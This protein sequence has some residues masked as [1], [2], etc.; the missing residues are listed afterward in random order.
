MTAT[1]PI[2]HS[3]TAHFIERWN[4]VKTNKYASNPRYSVLDPGFGAPSVQNVVGQLS[5]RLSDRLHLSH[6]GYA[7]GTSDMKIYAQ[8]VRSADKW[9]QGIEHE[10]SVQNAYIDLIS[11]A[12]RIDSYPNH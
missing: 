1:G 7:S 5:S 3:F 10:Q 4:F 11:H 8:L 12:N 6:S 2:V 9:S